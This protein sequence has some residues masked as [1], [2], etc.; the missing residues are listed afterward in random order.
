MTE[1]RAVVVCTANPCT[2]CGRYGRTGDAGP[3]RHTADHPKGPFLYAESAYEHGVGIARSVYGES[4][5]R[6]EVEAHTVTPWV[7]VIDPEPGEAPITYRG[8]LARV[9][10]P[11][12]R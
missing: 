3:G 4:A 6:V 7:P 8:R 12:G 9:I 5:H 11:R 2:Y 1:Y 10:A